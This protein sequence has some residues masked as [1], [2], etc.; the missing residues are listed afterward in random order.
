LPRTAACSPGDFESVFRALLAGGHDAVICITVGSALSGTYTAA[1]IARDAMPDAPVHVIDSGSASMAIGFLVLLAAEMARRG[2]TADAIVG[3]VLRRRPD[4]KCYIALETLEYL[5]R[6]GRISGAQAAIGSVLSVK[7]I[8]T[9]TEGRV[10]TADKPRTSGRARQRVLELLAQRPVERAWVLHTQAPG[11][12]AFADELAQALGLPRAVV[13]IGLI[14]PAV[15]SH[16]G[17]GA[18]GAVVLRHPA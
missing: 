6:G 9:I 14:G 15:A 17:P 12:E 16:V 7:P 1:Q 8:I 18:Y 4:T 2:E 5:K 13:P 3:E 11:I 10:E